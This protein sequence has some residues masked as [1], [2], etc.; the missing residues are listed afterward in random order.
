LGVR[1]PKPAREKGWM[2]KMAKMAKTKP[3]PKTNIILY[4]LAIAR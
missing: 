2:A 3:K 4:Y 1:P